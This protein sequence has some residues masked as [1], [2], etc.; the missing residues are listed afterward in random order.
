MILR[1]IRRHRQGELC[2][3][4]IDLAIWRIAF[5]GAIG[6]SGRHRIAEVL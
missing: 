3:P 2:G 6:G 5:V 4:F 1:F